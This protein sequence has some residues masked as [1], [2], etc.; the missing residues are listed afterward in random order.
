MV[1]TDGK[2]LK[3]PFLFLYPLYHLL[4]LLFYHHLPLHHYQLYRCLLHQKTKQLLLFLQF[5]LH[6]YISF[7]SRKFSNNQILACFNNNKR[8]QLPFPLFGGLFADHIRQRHHRQ[9]S[10][11]VMCLELVL[12]QQLR[13]QTALTYVEHA[14]LGTLLFD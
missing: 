7:L 1:Q 4:H 12:A 14:A 11:Y 6:K 3:M 8:F 13:R 10:S 5:Q 2:R 9:T